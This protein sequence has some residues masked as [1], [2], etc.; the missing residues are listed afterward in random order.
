MQTLYLGNCV[1]QFSVP[2]TN[3]KKM[4]RTADGQ[5]RITNPAINYNC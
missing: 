1:T 3:K 4:A 2:A 5:T